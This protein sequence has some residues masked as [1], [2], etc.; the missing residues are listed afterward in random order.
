VIDENAPHRLRGG[1][2]EV[3]PIVPGRILLAKHP[4]EDFV[5]QGS[6]L[7]AVP[8]LLVCQPVGGQCTQLLVDQR[9]EALESVPA[10]SDARVTQDAGDLPVW[11]DGHAWVVE[12]CRL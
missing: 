11:L 9:E 6:R 7:E 2:E 8:P 12:C 4:Q 10:N 5:D 1:I 3:T